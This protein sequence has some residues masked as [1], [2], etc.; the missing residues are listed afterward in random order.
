MT[1]TRSG[2]TPEAIEKLITQRVNEALANQE[3]NCNVELIVK[4]KSQNGDDDGNGNGGGNGDGNRGGNGNRGNNNGNGNR[5]GRNGGAGGVA[6]VARVCTY[7]DFLNCQP[8]KFSG[9]E[10]LVGLA[11]WFEKMEYVFRISNCPM[12]SQ[13]KLA[14]CTLLDGALTWWNS[15]VQSIG[16]DEEMSWKDMMKLMIDVYYPRNEIQKLENELWNLCV[17]GTDGLPDNIK[18][19]V[20]S[21]KPTRLQEAIKMANSL[22]DQKVRTY[23]ARNAENKRKFDNNPRDNRN[24]GNKAANNDARGRAYALGGGDGNPDSNIITAI[25]HETR[26]ISDPRFG[27]KVNKRVESNSEVVFAS[28]LKG[29]D[30]SSPCTDSSWVQPW[31]SDLSES[32]ATTTVV[33]HETMVAVAWV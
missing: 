13:V 27:H 25:F 5:N 20:N 2:M 1:I 22:M 4:G 8:R 11:R 28:Q 24:R 19:N 10:G 12:D 3:A 17:K 7:N 16:V 32:E 9:T 18:R 23:A 33:G 26:M 31:L 29:H 21:S 14:T 30:S 6:P 15:H